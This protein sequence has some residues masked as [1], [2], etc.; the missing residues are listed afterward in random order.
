RGTD[1][2]CQVFR[3]KRGA[4]PR[5]GQQPR[6]ATNQRCWKPVEVLPCTLLHDSVACPQKWPTLSPARPNIIRV[7]PDV[8]REFVCEFTNNPPRPQPPPRASWPS[9]AACGSPSAALLLPGARLLVP[10]HMGRGC[11]GLRGDS[12]DPQSLTKR[13]VPK[14]LGPK[15]QGPRWVV[16]EARVGPFSTHLPP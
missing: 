3:D 14:K 4:C 2:A 11:R 12:T 9:F 6:Q 16:G 1:P 7:L 15:G 10:D 13:Q 5:P 8:A